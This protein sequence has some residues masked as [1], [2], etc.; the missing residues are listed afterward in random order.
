MVEGHSV[1]RIA[2][3][4]TRRLVGRAYRATSPNGRFAEGAKLIDGRTFSR[5]EAIGK[6]LFAFFAC[7]SGKA[8]DVVMHVHFG[9]AGRWSVAD[10][11]KAPADTAT[12]RLRLEGGGLVSQL[13]AMTVQHT[14]CARTRRTHCVRTAHALRHATAPSAARAPTMFRAPAL[15]AQSRV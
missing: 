12:T 14:R 6:N 5:C 1:H 8:P 13:S 7:S 15:R 3:Q 10:P 11:A 4:H 2:T 9:M